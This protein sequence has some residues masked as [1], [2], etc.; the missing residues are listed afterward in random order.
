VIE[1]ESHPSEERLK[2]RSRVAVVLSVIPGL[3]HIY[4]GWFLLGFILMLGTSLALAIALLLGFATLG[5]G[6]VVAIVGYWGLVG[7]HAYNAE[8]KRKHHLLPEE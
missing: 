3:G 8:D 7:L 5:V 1:E 2:I 4:K 6:A